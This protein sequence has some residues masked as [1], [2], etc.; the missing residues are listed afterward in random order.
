MISQQLTP[1]YSLHT[2]LFPITP[3]YVE[4]RVCELLMYRI[5]PAPNPIFWEFPRDLVY[6]YYKPRY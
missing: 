5:T 4:T 1:D 3:P 2:T 6:T